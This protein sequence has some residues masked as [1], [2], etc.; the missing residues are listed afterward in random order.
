[1]FFWVKNMI[2]FVFIFCCS[3]NSFSTVFDTTMM[4]VKSVALETVGNNMQK[5]AILFL[6]LQVD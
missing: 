3:Y 6:M 4:M 5:V 1:M 2:H